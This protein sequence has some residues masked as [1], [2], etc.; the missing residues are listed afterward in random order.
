MDV[1][2]TTI[3]NEYINEAV[4]EAVQTESPAYISDILT[5]GSEISVNSNDLV[6]YAH[7]GEILQY[8]NIGILGIIIG[9]LIIGQIRK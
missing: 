2:E 5:F 3:D 9:L 7:S 6:Q 8:V 1:T 4:T